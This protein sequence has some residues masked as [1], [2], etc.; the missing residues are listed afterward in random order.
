MSGPCLITARHGYASWLT[1]GVETW[2][3]GR[4]VVVWQRAEVTG[5]WSVLVERWAVQRETRA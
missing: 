2:E 1:P 3:L 5:P 4:R